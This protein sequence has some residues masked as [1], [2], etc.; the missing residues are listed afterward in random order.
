MPMPTQI[1]NEITALQT[2]LTNTGNLNAATFPVRNALAVQ[3]GQLASDIQAAIS[4]NAGM[5]DT[6]TPPVMPQDIVTGVL[7]LL[8][9]AQTQS[10]L[11][12]L[13]GYAARIE[14]NIE[15]G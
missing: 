11:T 4:P 10:T 5:L 14:I 13:E 7:S 12:D 2:A 15:N 3:A 8:D 9:S 1:V 6:F